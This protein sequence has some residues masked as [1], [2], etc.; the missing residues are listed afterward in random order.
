MAAV[1]NLYTFTLTFPKS[2]VI[3]ILNVLRWQ[4]QPFFPL[5]LRNFV[6]QHYTFSF[7]NILLLS[8]DSCSSWNPNQTLK[9]DSQK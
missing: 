5:G 1:Q 7:W 2:M 6:K 9:L 3:V 8:A 4:K